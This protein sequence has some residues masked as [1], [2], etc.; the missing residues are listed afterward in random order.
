MSIT[1]L[2][3]DDILNIKKG[4]IVHGV[5][6][7]GVMGAGIARAIRDKYCGVYID[8][9]RY[10]DNAYNKQSLLGNIVVSNINQDLMIVSGFTQE[11]YG[12]DKNTVYVNYN[13]VESVFKKVN[14]LAMI[15]NLPV[16]FPLIGAGFANGNWDTIR[17]IINNTLTRDG[18][19]VVFDNN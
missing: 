11:Y 15:N 9:K 3:H 7:Q 16:Y 2:L 4:I 14:E 18:T 10:C 13:A 12:R 5:N 1:L 6:C 8:Y 17:N 19:L